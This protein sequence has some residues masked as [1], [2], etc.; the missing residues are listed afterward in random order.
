MTDTPLV[1]IALCTYNGA[2]YLKQ[3]IDTL[4]NQ[5]YTNIEIVITDD[6]SSDD[7]LS[8]LE[9]YAAADSRIIIHKNEK[10]LGYAKNFEKAIHLCKGKYIAL[11]D[12]DDIWA[13]N[14]I[15][16][17][18]NAIGNALLIYH[19]SEFVDN[20]EQSLGKM[21]DVLNMYSGNDPLALVFDN[22]VS[23][24]SCMFK[25]ELLPQLGPFNPK[26]FHDWWIA[27]VA[28]N[29]GS[30]V[31]LNEVLV[32]YRR[33]HEAITTILTAN[34]KVAKVKQKFPELNIPW[35]EHC[36]TFKGKRQVV[37]KQVLD[38]Y[39][40]K[41]LKSNLKFFFFLV[42]YLKP[43]FFT[44]KKSDGSKFNYARKMAFRK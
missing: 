19:D 34:M 30:I 20:E 29:K 16:L 40:K 13:L 26:L 32:K 23:G 33:H 10:N 42:R 15:E 12:Q 21:S 9:Q 8:I 37:I 44:K 4:L 41:G 1:S 35:I 39:D 6:Q 25:A 31:Y 28:A 24:H 18:V 43:L 11:S 5:T 27:F 17:L 3:Q 36:S 14:K 2:K 22:C 38:N 7:T